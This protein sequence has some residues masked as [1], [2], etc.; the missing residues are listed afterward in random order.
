MGKDS[1]DFR[2][3]L[4]I[5]FKLLKPYWAQA[6]FLVVVLFII[7]GFD[8]AERYLFKLVV[9]KGTAFTEK[10]ISIEIFLKFTILIGVV[11]LGI[12]IT[13]TVLKWYRIH[14]INS[15]EAKMMR[16]LKKLMF[17]HILRL[18]HGF[19]TSHKIGSLISKLVR[20]GNAV[21]RFT[22][23]VVFNFAP[24]VFQLIV[25]G[26]SL[27]YF[28][29]I[30]AVIV[31]ATV[32]LFIGFS[33]VVQNLQKKI[34]VASNAAEDS[35][36]GHI[37]NFFT[38][39]E[40]IKYFGKE[41]LI[42]NKF[43]AISE[44]TRRAMLRNWNYYRFIN[45]GQSLIIG[46]GTFAIVYFPLKDFLADEITLGTLVF[47]YTVFANIL[48]PMYSFTY[49]LRG[50]YQS[51]GDFEAL[52]KYAKIEQEVKDKVNAPVLKVSHG[53]IAFSNVAFKYHS[54]GM[55]NNFSLYIKPH[56]KV[57]LVGYSG[58]GKTTLIKLLYRLYDVEK[59]SVSIDGIDVK[60]IQQESL[61][62]ELSIVP[63]EAVLFDDTIYNNIAFS[64]PG[65]TRVEVMAAM[66]FAQ[67]DRTVKTFP[68]KEHT[69][70]GERGIKL[71][72][73]EKQRVSIARAILAN[74]KILILDEAT[75]HLD[76]K[77][78]HDIQRDLKKL[79][80]GRTTIMIAHRLST[81]MSAD[82]IIVLDNG[83]IVQ[84]GTHSALIKKPG[85]YRKL[86]RLQKGGYIQ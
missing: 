83:K 6:L 84:E 60:N 15:I 25:S 73:G 57:A 38:N 47:V 53:G 63:Q 22:D 32:F 74:K 41:V 37:S 58:S 11:F 36:R 48:D 5:Y 28:S 33:M 78:E 72:G 69:I 16:D 77:T 23:S 24:L 80:I 31:T 85:T 44:K 82:R 55:F 54:R 52:F 39:I 79:M 71:S 81:I 12:V 19:F 66:K 29:T 61:R 75:S 17:D 70:V 56:E 68:K 30:P 9:D 42:K 26:A 35:E 2:Y 64:R 50:F 20:G 45:A 62:S 13:R 18:S 1:I 51:M 7:E 4:R 27:L 46:L 14:I 67:L 43:S 40:S 21:E 76:S 10:T 59:G 8:T 86:W 65:A 49:G 34:M 3:N